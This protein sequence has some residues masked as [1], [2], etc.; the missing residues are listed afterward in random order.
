MFRWDTRELAMRL[1]DPADLTLRP[2]I[3]RLD[4]YYSPK[5]PQFREGLRHILEAHD[6]DP[7]AGAAAEGGSKLWTPESER[8][9]A[10]AERPSLILPGM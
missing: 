4:R 8:A 1:E 2:L 3:E 6:I 9:E 5:L 10:A 7:P